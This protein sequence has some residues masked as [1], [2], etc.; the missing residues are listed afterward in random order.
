MTLEL[1]FEELRRAVVKLAT[2]KLHVDTKP[3][4]DTGGLVVGS[5]C[6]RAFTSR[7]VVFTVLEAQALAELPFTLQPR[8]E[9]F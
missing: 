5:I 8:F 6:E 1:P 2:G 9:R 3:D 7:R 4:K